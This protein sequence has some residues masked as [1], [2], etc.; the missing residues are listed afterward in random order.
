MSES[1]VHSRLAHG[2]KELQMSTNKTVSAGRSG[3]LW[4]C[5]LFRI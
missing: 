2:L 1:G 3:R 4:I 5:S